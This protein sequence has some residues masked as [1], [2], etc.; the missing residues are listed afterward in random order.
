MARWLYIRGLSYAARHLTNGL[1][2]D[3]QVRKAERGHTLLDGRAWHEFPAVA[4]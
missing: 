2:L 1:S 4:S 3:S